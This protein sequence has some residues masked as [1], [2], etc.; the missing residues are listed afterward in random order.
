MTIPTVL[1]KEIQ[2][3]FYKMENYLDEQ[4]LFYGS[5]LRGDYVPY[6]SDIDAMIIT[7]NEYSVLAKLQHFLRASKRD[8]EKVV[9]YLNGTLI[10]GY[11]IRHIDPVKRIECEIGIY[12]N[13]FRNVLYDEAVTKA[14]Q[15]PFLLYLL[16]S[17]VKIFY[18]YLPI[19]SKKQ[20]AYLKRKIMNDSV[21]KISEYFVVKS[22]KKDKKYENNDD[23]NDEINNDDNNDDNIGNNNQESINGRNAEDEIRMVNDIRLK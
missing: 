5:I 6:K 15:L 19:L 16:L 9:W 4:M 1:P 7:D 10:Y 17:I 3:F 12:N 14:K 23:N 2:E 18:Y 11:K 22:H 8:V 21:G 13:R 20:Y